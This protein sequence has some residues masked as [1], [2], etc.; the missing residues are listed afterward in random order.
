MKTNEKRLY[1]E[2]QNLKNKINQR[3]NEKELNYKSTF[4]NRSLFNNIN[5]N[6]RSLMNNNSFSPNKFKTNNILNQTNTNPNILSPLRLNNSLN[7]NMKKVNSQFS[8]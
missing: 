2:N 6:N 8:P 5:N 4:Q 1:K 7:F 3:E